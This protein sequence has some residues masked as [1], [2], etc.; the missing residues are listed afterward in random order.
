M[1]FDWLRSL[2]RRLAPGYLIRSPR[3][4]NWRPAVQVDALE[5]RAAPG[6]LAGAI[7]AAAAAQ[8]AAAS[9]DEAAAADLAD[10][11]WSASLNPFGRRA[12][13]RA[14]SVPV[15]D[16]SIPLPAQ[17]GRTKNAEAR[18]DSSAGDPGGHLTRLT[19]EFLL[20]DGRKRLG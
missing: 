8:A 13:E 9:S 6:A 12:D 10:L 14:E 16:E 5:S 11:T 15:T 1:A 18:E 2:R 19:D 3:R 4:R 20:P 17:P 7:G